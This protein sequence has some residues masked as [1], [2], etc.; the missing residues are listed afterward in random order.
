MPPVFRML[1]ALL[2]VS[3]CAHPL[4]L[5]KDDALTV[6]PH[7][8]SDSGHI[9]V[10]AMVNGTGPFKFALDTGASISAIFE[11]L[12]KEAS[13]EPIAGT[14][15]HVLGMTGSGDYPVADVARISIGSET[16][17]GARVAILPNSTPIAAHIDGILGVDFLSR[18]AVWYSQEDRALRLY[19]NNLVAEHSYDSWNSIKLSDMAIGKSGANLYV[20]DM[21]IQAQRIPTLFDLGTTESVMNRR[22][23][24]LLDVRT[25][26]PRQETDL[27]GVIGKVPILAQIHIWRLRVENLYFRNRIFLVSELPVFDALDLGRTPFAIVGTSFFKQR[28]FVIDFA[29]KRLLVK[30]RE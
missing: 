11:D 24:K 21:L 27:Y 26:A 14:V 4:V 18:Y 6:I 15:A 17:E 25:R 23:A 22:G 9:V 12:R 28:D 30:N 20:F 10:E 16:W 19:S 3:G 8:T 7:Q 1:V 29:Q 5:D 13:V 2:L